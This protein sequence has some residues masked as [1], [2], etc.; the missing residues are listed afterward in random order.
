M[1]NLI[2]LLLV[3]LLQISCTTSTVKTPERYLTRADLDKNEIIYFD[4]K[5]Q[6]QIVFTDDLCFTLTPYGNVCEKT[7]T[8]KKGKVIAKIPESIYNPQDFW[9]SS[10]RMLLPSTY[11]IEIQDDTINNFKYVFISVSALNSKYTIKDLESS[12]LMTAE[13]Y[14]AKQQDEFNESIAHLNSLDQSLFNAVKFGFAE[15]F[16]GSIESGANVNCKDKNDMTPL[17]LATQNGFYEMVQFLIKKGANVNAV[18]KNNSTALMIAASTGNYDIVKLLLA[19]KAK[20]NIR[21]KTMN[22]SAYDMAKF[23]NYTE[24]MFLLRSAG[25]K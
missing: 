2:I 13:E 11:V 3:I 4:E 8:G 7:I 12:K 16:Y 14:E 22:M 25:A 20:V 6:S 5:D 19:N 9:D 21:E 18:T 24:I 10:K 1:K 17:M 15:S 23:N